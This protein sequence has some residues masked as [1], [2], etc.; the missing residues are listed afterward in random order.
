MNERIDEILVRVAEIETLGG[1]KVLTNASGCFFMQNNDLF[2]V[3]ARHVVLIVGYPLGFH[4]SVHHLPIVRSAVIASV[5]GIPFKSEPYFLTDARLHR[6]TS[7][8]PVIARLSQPTD[9]VGESPT[10][11]YLLGV[12][13]AALDVSNRDPQEDE[14]LGL[15][16]AWYASLIPEI[17]QSTERGS[18]S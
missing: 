4:D 11:W 5:Y 9:V 16:T 14:R 18:T 6:G 3:T 1:G 8:A 17:I 13:S 15:N 10:R 12:H 7:G 2:L